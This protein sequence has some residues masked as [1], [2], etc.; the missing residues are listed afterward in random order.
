MIYFTKIGYLGRLG[1][2][3]FQFASSV[4][5]AK[6]TGHDIFFPLENCTEFD[7]NGPINPKTN[8]P[9]LVK[10]DLLDCFNIPVSFFKRSSEIN[11]GSIIQEKKFTFDPDMFNVQD[12]SDLYGFFQTEKYFKPISR[13]IIEY[14]TFKSE[15]VNSSSKYWSKNIKGF[16]AGSKPVS[17]HIRRGDYTLYPNHHPLCSRDYY[18]RAISL[19]EPEVKFLIF[20]DDLD[21]CRENFSSNRFHVV[22]SGSPYIDLKLITMCDHHI[23]ANSSFSWWGSWLNQKESKRVIC[24][25]NWF[26]PA[27][28]KDQR[29]VYCEDW[30]TI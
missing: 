19:F 14:F 27:I 8:S 10:C 13:D 29:D 16:L 22:D 25:A 7:P 12:G 15:I 1:N 6:K 5:I 24:P 3:M 28:N 4:A 26:G 17:I 30:K 21:W 11:I 2:Q 9:T 18:N 20:S 23:N